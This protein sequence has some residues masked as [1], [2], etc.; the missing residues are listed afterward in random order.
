MRSFKSL[1]KFKLNTECH[2]GKGGH[3]IIRPNTH[4]KERWRIK[5]KNTTVKP[6]IKNENAKQTITNG[7]KN[8]EE[9]RGSSYTMSKCACNQ[10]QLIMQNAKWKARL[11]VR[12]RLPTSY[13]KSKIYL[14]LSFGF[15]KFSFKRPTKWII[16]GRPLKATN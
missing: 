13:L 4:S 5:K 11:W 8:I 6:I 12:K 14:L 1:N 10:S 2:M 16:I 3:I 9:K 7:T 15:G